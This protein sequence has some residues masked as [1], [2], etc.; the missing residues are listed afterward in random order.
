M[1]ESGRGVHSQ[2]TLFKPSALGLVD[3]LSQKSLNA[4]DALERRI[5]TQLARA[6]HYW[7]Y[8]KEDNF[9]KL[10]NGV[11]CLIGLATLSLASSGCN[12]SE[13]VASPLSKINVCAKLQ[14]C[15]TYPNN[16]GRLDLVTLGD[17]E[18]F[19]IS[20][21]DPVGHRVYS[22]SSFADITKPNADFDQFACADFPLSFVESGQAVGFE[23]GSFK[24][25]DSSMYFRPK[26]KDG[27][28]YYTLDGKALSCVG[29]TP[30]FT[31]PASEHDALLEV[32]SKR[33]AGKEDGHDAYV[34]DQIC[35]P[36]CVKGSVRVSHPY[37]KVCAEE[38][39]MGQCL[40]YEW[41][42]GPEWLPTYTCPK[43]TMRTVTYC[44]Q[45]EGPQIILDLNSGEVVTGRSWLFGG[46]SLEPTGKVAKSVSIQPSDLKIDFDH[47]TARVTFDCNKPDGGGSLQAMIAPQV[48]KHMIKNKFSRSARAEAV[49][50]GDSKELRQDSP[51]PEAVREERAKDRA[52]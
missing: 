43:P 12:S 29:I 41:A 38:D 24:Q 33:H 47:A 40:R 31:R 35:D 3:P 27:R 20:G 51:T 49:S 16:G 28:Y 45:V 37:Y 25:A 26:N 8:K 32:C 17:G 23:A 52:I 11:F 5:F 22:F 44:N 4:K 18:A 10:K 21:G 14:N 39:F 30:E 13:E 6:V 2:G 36:V 7:V 48:L 9:M 46:F 42:G 15:E 1:L 19:K 50:N 34:S